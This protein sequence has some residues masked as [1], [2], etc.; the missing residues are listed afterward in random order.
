MEKLA[1]NNSGLS[2]NN[3]TENKIVLNALLV[4]IKV[5]EIPKQKIIILYM[6][7]FLPKNNIL[8]KIIYF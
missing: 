6:L 1:L 3:N 5:E 4:L 2:N 7:L 8:I